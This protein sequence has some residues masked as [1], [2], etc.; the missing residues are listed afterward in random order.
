MVY[1]IYTYAQI[2]EGDIIDLDVVLSATKKKNKG[3]VEED[4]E[5]SDGVCGSLR[6][7]TR[8]SRVEV[9]SI[10]APTRK[11]G[12]HITLKRIKEFCYQIDYAK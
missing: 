12:R 1:V 8:R 2:R 4:G 6:P 9:V 10:G 5:S 3:Q 11:G 7:R